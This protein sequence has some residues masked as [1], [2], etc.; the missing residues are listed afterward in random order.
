MMAMA[1][2]PAWRYYALHSLL[3]ETIWDGLVPN[4]PVTIDGD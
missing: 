4:A 2:P 3:L 1:C